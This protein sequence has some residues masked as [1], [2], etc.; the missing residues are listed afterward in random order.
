MD[1]RKQGL[2]RK[3]QVKRT[4]LSHRKGGK[5]HDCEYFVLD[6]THDKFAAV[7]LRAYAGACLR[8]YPLLARDISE[9]LRKM[10]SDLS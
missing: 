7:A 5:H 8:E 4:D 6:L 2:Y 3:F 1:D 10:K 9:K